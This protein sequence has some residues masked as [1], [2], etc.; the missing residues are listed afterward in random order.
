MTDP[1]TPLLLKRHRG[2]PV[3][4]RA[5]DVSSAGM[6]VTTDRPLRIDERLC[7]DID[8]EGCAHVDAHARVVREQGLHCYSLRFEDVDASVAQQLAGAYRST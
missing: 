8:L 6:R 7:F 3:A 5:S 4:A 1:A 2:R